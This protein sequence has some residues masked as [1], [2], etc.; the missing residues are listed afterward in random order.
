MITRRKLIRTATIAIAGAP[1][2]TNAAGATKSKSKKPDRMPPQVGDAL[3][4]PSWEN[5]GRVV[6]ASEIVS[7]AK[8]ITVY[9]RDLASGVTRERS[10]LNQI[11]V[12]R[13]PSQP[14][15]EPIDDTRLNT[16]IMVYSGVC[17]HTA[18]A[19]TEWNAESG[20]I[21][22]PCHSSEFDPRQRAKVINGPARRALP[23]LP[24]EIRDNMLIVAG[25]F[26]A[27]VGAKKKKSF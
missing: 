4:Y 27:K 11:L 7:G 12:L 22:C 1:A 2:L 10:R 26:S 13:L 3:A 25:D 15:L 16:D 14:P 6:L 18:C 23:S 5:E 19:V 24:V 21:I 8:P 17:T 9:P 20:H